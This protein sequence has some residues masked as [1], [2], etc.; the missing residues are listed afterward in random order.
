MAVLEA[1]IW[2]RFSDKNRAKWRDEVRRELG[3]SE[4]DFVYGFVGRITRDKGVN[5]LLEA[6]FSLNTDG[7]TPADRAF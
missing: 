1:S 3:L 7:K 2:I 5:E 6:Y 4:N